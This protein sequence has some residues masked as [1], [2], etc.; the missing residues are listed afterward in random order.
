MFID[1]ES[2]EIFLVKF[3]FDVING[4]RILSFRRRSLVLNNVAYQSYLSLF[5]EILPLTLPEK[6]SS[7]EGD[8]ECRTS[9]NGWSSVTS[10]G[11]R[12]CIGCTISAL[13][14]QS[15]SKE[16]THT[17]SVHEWEIGEETSYSIS[18]VSVIHTY[19]RTYLIY[20]F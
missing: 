8:F 18:S 13:P 14:S 20:L 10:H 1:D 7:L 12:F 5:L 2:L 17:G 9:Q 4:T 16:T 19:I 15:V 11:C 3:K 6:M